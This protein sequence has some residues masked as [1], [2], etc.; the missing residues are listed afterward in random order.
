MIFTCVCVK[1]C[2]AGFVVLLC[3]RDVS[4]PGDGALRTWSPYA[5][6]VIRGCDFIRISEHHLGVFWTTLESTSRRCSYRQASS[7]LLGV[8]EPPAE[9]PTPALTWKSCLVG[10]AL[11]G[12]LGGKSLLLNLGTNDA[13]RDGICPVISLP[14]QSKMRPV[15]LGLRSFLAS[16]LIFWNL[17]ARGSY[18]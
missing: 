18:R 8:A 7:S 6:N 9:P 17:S 12:R 3:A 14:R 11:G 16:A 4:E 15:S 1:V 5:R 2:V 10:S 13:G